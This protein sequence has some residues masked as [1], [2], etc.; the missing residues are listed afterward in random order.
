MSNVPTTTNTCA[1]CAHRFPDLDQGWHDDVVGLQSA[2]GE[3]V[4]QVALSI[5]G[6]LGFQL[7]PGH[8]PVTDTSAWNEL[9]ELHWPEWRLW[10]EDGGVED[11][12]TV[13]KFLDV[14]V[15]TTSNAIRA[16][17]MDAKP[18]TVAAPPSFLEARVPR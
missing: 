18:S 8:L 17:E 12:P 10:G 6:Q 11:V 16:W 9:I 1:V 5:L 15:E 7:I 4:M 2:S 3:Q 14:L 13:C